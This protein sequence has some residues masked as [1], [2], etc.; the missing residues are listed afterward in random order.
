MISPE[1]LVRRARKRCQRHRQPG[2]GGY[3]RECYLAE[4]EEAI[5]EEHPEMKRGCL[6]PH[7]MRIS[8]DEFNK[9][10][11]DVHS[12]LRDVPLHDVSAVDLPG[13]GAGRTVSDLGPL[14]S[15]ERRASTGFLVQALFS[16]RLLLGRMLGWDRDGNRHPEESYVHRLTDEQRARSLVPPSTAHGPF[17]VL[18]EFPLESLSEIRNATVHAFSCMVLQPADSGYRFYWAVYVKPVSRLTPVYM[19]LIEPFRRFIVYPTTL[20]R[21][22]SSWASTY[23]GGTETTTS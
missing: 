9:L 23:A 18:Y 13:G 21:L 16:V 3:C 19:A 11:L 7:T 2:V 22:R 5:A 20:R 8:A 4:L 14:L 15:P 12:F 6:P 10:D 1:E 17:R